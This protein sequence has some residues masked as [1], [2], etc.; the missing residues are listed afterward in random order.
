ML[1][2]YHHVYA[3]IVAF[4]EWAVCIEVYMVEY[5]IS[6]SCIEDGYRVFFIGDKETISIKPWKAK[7]VG[8][9]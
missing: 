1:D 8:L 2:E 4:T 3:E 7:E 9:A 6:R 5:W